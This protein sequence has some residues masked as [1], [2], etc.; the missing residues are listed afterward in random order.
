[1]TDPH[2]EKLS[3]DLRAA[4]ATLSD[5]E[6]RFLVDAYYIIQEDR[7][8][9]GNQVKAMN[10]E[11]HSLLQWFFEQNAT[12]EDQLKGALDKYSAAKP[13]GQWMRRQYGIGPVISA[14]LIAHI[15]INKA[16]TT[17]HIWRFAGLDPT[18]IWEKGKKRPWNAELKTLCWKI[19]QSFMKFS[20]RDECFYGKLYIKRKQY[21]VD[22]NDSGGNATRAAELLP[23]FNKST[24]AYGHLKSGKLPP[25]QI[26]ARARRWAVK[27][28]L[29]HMHDKWWELEKGEKPVKPYIMSHWPDAKGGSHAHMIEA[30]E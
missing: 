30:P 25:A 20:G 22:R 17:G 21:E 11:P 28:F 10:A 24:E 7:K 23:K 5:E 12:L 15:D 19:G 2:I 18:S 27:L 13:I 9:S 29:S 8:R 1:V 6:A 26:D 14:G 16:P 4:A 3:V